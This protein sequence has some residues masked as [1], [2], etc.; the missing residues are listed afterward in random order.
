MKLKDDIENI[1]VSSPSEF[2]LNPILSI[3]VILGCTESSPAQFK[4]EISE[5]SHAQAG[6]H[7]QY[8]TMTIWDD[9]E[10]IIVGAPDKF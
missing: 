9:T 1:F 4:L 8:V 3:T 5:A 2:Q 10:N 6:I 7:I